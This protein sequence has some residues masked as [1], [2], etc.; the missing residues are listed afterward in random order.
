MARDQD[1]NDIPAVLAAL[2]AGAIVGNRN[3]AKKVAQKATDN[4]P[5]DTGFLRATVYRSA[6]DATNYPQAVSQAEARGTGRAVLPETERPADE[7][8]S[9]VAYAASYA[10]W[11]HEGTRHMAGRPWLAEAAARAD[12]AEEMAHALNAAI[13]AAAK[14][15]GGSEG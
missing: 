1:W 9:I 10:Y 8:T 13:K 14:H 3:A 5:L 6:S 4:C 2:H 15:S 7:L 11:V 12:V